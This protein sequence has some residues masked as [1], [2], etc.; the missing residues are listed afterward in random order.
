M[1]S[2]NI[3]FDTIPASIRK[4]GKYFEFNTRFAVRTLPANLQRMLVIGQRLAAGTVAA[5]VPT[6][7]F[8][9]AQAADYFG[10]GSLAHLM[11]RAAIT[12]NRYL[13]LT[14]IA[15]DDAGTAVAASGTIT[16][17]GP[18]TTS[19]TLSVFV[20]TQRVEL[21]IVAAD[22][23]TAIAT[24]LVAELAKYPDLPVTAAAALGVVTLTAKN[25]GTVAN[26]ID[27]AAECTANGITATVA[28]MAGGSVDPTLSTALAKVFSEQYHVVVTPYN[29]QANLVTLRDHL[30]AVSGS[31]EQRGAVGVYGFDGALA[32]AT[33]LA[34]QVNHGRV[35]GVYLRGTKSPSYE[36]ACAFGGVMAYEEDPARPLNTL[37][38][39]GISAP[40]IDQRLSRTEQE[41]CLNNGVAPLE[42]GPGE[43]V[44][45][46]RAITTYTK[47]PQGIT[48]IS[49]LDVTTVRTLDYVRKACR[50]RISLRFPREKLSSKTP[51][52]V[53]TELV[54]VLIKLEELEIVEE[55]AANMDG[56]IVERDLQDPNRLD[57]KIPCDVVNGLH[58]FAGRIDL[59]L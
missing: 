46:V 2:K 59:L 1:A 51:P 24:N 21:G 45:I 9:D 25:K 32:S 49:L 6:Q 41:S 19:G 16:F 29:D 44:Q 31:M 3:S 50:E 52:K 15:M 55:V 22:T 12:A 35:V 7:V 27:L 38:L 26:Q 33:T 14:V 11:C 58:V 13:D 54:D 43:R 53:K 4:P 39:K 40:A 57:A 34:G 37:E 5:L 47:D 48:D 17:T 20:G 10:N 23:A 8:S 56:L 42:V 28:A 30:D 36:I 18:A